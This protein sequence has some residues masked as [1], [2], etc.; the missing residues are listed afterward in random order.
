[1]NRLLDVAVLNLNNPNFVRER[2][3]A[4]LAANGISI[5]Q[6]KVVSANHIF[7]ANAVIVGLNSVN[8]INEASFP[9]GEHMVILGIRVFTDANATLASTDWIAGVDDAI[10][11]NGFM[12]VTNSGTI[13][14][15]DLPLTAFQP[16]ANFPNAGM[17]E[18][19]KPIIWKGQTALTINLR[20]PT[21]PA[22]A[23]LNARVELIGIKLI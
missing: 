17:V 13:E 20:F 3:A 16:A 5:P 19:S 2:V 23:N 22:T 18:L 6:N 4:L 10:A 8:I 15:K 14:A 11:K 9:E 1:M 7:A 12:N 21:V